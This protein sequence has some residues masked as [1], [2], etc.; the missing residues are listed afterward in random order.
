LS[1]S[2]ITISCRA[3]M[4]ALSSRWD[5]IWS[6]SGR[7]ALRAGKQFNDE[8]HRIAHSNAVSLAIM[9]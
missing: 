2:P 5:S 9:G 1:I 6:P 7:A 3:I 4:R 8:P